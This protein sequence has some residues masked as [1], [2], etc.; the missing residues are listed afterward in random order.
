LGDIKAM[1]DKFWQT[2]AFPPSQNR[3][4][5]SPT[6]FID[7]LEFGPINISVDKRSAQRQQ[8]LKAGMIEFPGG[9]FSC[10]VRN[11]SA[12][13]AALDVP[14]SIGIPDHFTLVIQTEGS[15]FFCH[16]VWRK[17]RRI[18][19]TFSYLQQASASTTPPD[20]LG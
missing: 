11:L 14:G 1:R 19:V 15:R 17:D 4:R 9:A 7:F 8:V 5:V 18:G 10:M 6:R 20:L 3:P 16:S 12:T 13:G 2:D